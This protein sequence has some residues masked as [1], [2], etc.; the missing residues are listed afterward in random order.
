MYFP[1]S[2]MLGAYVS[3]SNTSSIE[4]LIYVI[5]NFDTHLNQFSGGPMLCYSPPGQDT[6]CAQL[7][8]QRGHW[9][10]HSAGYF[11]SRGLSRR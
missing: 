6:K 7:C 5:F 11:I 8:A 10:P 2:S 9:T 3:G 4:L 1:V